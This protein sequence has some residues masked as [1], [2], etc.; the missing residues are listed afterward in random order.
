MNSGAMRCRRL[1]Q[2]HEHG[3]NAAENTVQLS[4]IMI[5]LCWLRECQHNVSDASEHRSDRLPPVVQTQNE[6]TSLIRV[7]VIDIQPRIQLILIGRVAFSGVALMRV[8]FVSSERIMKC[9]LI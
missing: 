5:S 1:T 4:T 7:S 8:M 3:I 6:T 2:K 9:W